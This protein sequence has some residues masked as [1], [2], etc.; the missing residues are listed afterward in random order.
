M[1]NFLKQIRLVKKIGFS[2]YLQYI[3]AKQGAEIKVKILRKEI[4]VR[5]G[6]PDLGVAINC[7]SSQIETP[8]RFEPRSKPINLHLSK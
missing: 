6:T 4:F 1:K 3:L 7:F 8:I 5:K 2:S